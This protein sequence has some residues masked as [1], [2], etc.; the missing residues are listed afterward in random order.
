M[1]HVPVAVRAY[2]TPRNPK[3]RRTKS[4]GKE[5]P[6][7]ELA[8]VITLETTSDS[9]QRL[10]FG[11][12]RV[13]K[14]DT[15][16]E[17]GVFYAEDLAEQERQRLAQYC[18]GHRQGDAK[19]AK[20]LRLLPREELLKKVFFPVAYD[21]RAVVVG[22]NLP[23]IISRLAVDS[24]VAR[25]LP[26]E[27]GFSFTLLDYKDKKGKR[28]LDKLYPRI[29]V[30]ALD[31]KRALMG[32]TSA[33]RRSFSPKSSRRRLVYRG[34]FVDLLTLG[35]AL[36]GE[37]KS[38]EPL[39]KLF[40][41]QQGDVSLNRDG[42]STT[43]SV[44]SAREELTATWELYQRLLTEYQNHRIPLRPS[45]A[46]SPASIGKAILREMGIVLP[47]VRMGPGVELTKEEV[48]G[49]AMASYYGGR[50]ECLIREVLV[51]VIYLDTRSMFPTVFCLAHCWDLL[52]ARQVVIEDA[53]QDAAELL[54]RLTAD[55]LL[56]PETWSDVNM[57]VQ[58]RPEGDIL[59][60]RCSFNQH[61]WGQY[62]IGLNLETWLSNSPITQK[63]PWYA[64][65]D[66]LA[67]KVL[68][69]KPPHVVR[70]LRFRPIGRQKNL[71]P[72]SLWGGTQID[73]KREDFFQRLVEERQRVKQSSNLGQDERERRSQF[74]K[75]LAN[76]SCYGIFVELNRQ[77]DPDTEVDVHGLWTFQC[78]VDHPESEGEFF[79]PIIGTLVSAG[80]RLILALLEN[81]VQS[82]GGTWAF[83]DTD[84]M[85]VVASETGGLIECVGGR[86][87]LPDGKPAIKALSWQEVEAIRAR[88]AGLNPY[89]QSLAP[90]SILKLEE[91]NFDK[92]DPGRR[93]Q[94]WC[95]AVAAKRYALF[96]RDGDK[97][98]LRKWSEHALGNHLE[99]RDPRTA[100]SV[101]DW[102]EAAWKHIIETELWD[103]PRS[104]TEFPWADQLACT[105]LAIS[106]PWMMEWFDRF[107]AKGTRGGKKLYSKAVK[108]FN[109]FEHPSLHA[110][111]GPSAQETGDK[112][113]CLVAAFPVKDP[114]ATLW[115]NIHDP[116]GPCFRVVTSL[117]ETIGPR[118]CVGMIYRDLIANHTLQPEVK[119]I[120]PDGEPCTSMTRGLLS[121]RHI[122]VTDVVHIGKEANDLELVKAGMIEDE[123]AVLTTYELQG[124]LWETVQPILAQMP[125]ARIQE[126]TGYS[127]R[128]VYYIREGKKRP[129]NKRL[130]QVA[131]MAAGW[132]REVLE[133]HSQQD[134]RATDRTLIDQ[135]ATFLADLARD[136]VS[137]FGIRPQPRAP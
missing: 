133:N 131:A 115:V 74:F 81:E 119:F 98:N 121:R 43:D 118:T 85:A 75:F 125:A 21:A 11:L 84:S 106:T 101:P 42:G 34:D 20:P 41:V 26:Y 104:Q 28:K 132:A 33:W 50:A 22:F 99:P 64:M 91:D 49:Y 124:D 122:H 83:M 29:A 112:P 9:S 108:P 12:Y 63:L 47:P 128:E 52:T 57:I 30:K 32:F 110:K 65:A 135:C 54:D 126:E 117:G 61:P 18:A 7:P 137:S 1:S 60:A 103:R 97:V 55:D 71:H 14:R 100:Q 129:S 90:G 35:Y 58:V 76:S 78:G 111:L 89:D 23:F 66:C 27:G 80:A 36:T 68:T 136:R 120:G 13:Y 69:G 127:R 56:R 134:D 130:P 39:C 116:A 102:I 107:N 113:I 24:T 6:W 45:K 72:I 40:Q 2:A 82:L 38:L 59:P 5:P 53:T 48:F 19:R 114:R 87:E 62:T 44:M 109:F 92:D 8:I 3:W 77:D 4:K 37:F 17:E 73:P 105:R 51:P 86:E 70:A 15:L 94:L 16:L 88:F 46:Y 10:T 123:E 79:F 93:K 96:N 31:S 67:S 25:R 95:Y